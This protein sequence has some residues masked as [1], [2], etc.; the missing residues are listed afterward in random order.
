[1]DGSAT[2]TA[3]PRGRQRHVS[4]TWTAARR[5]APSPAA[6]AAQA[7][8]LRGHGGCRLALPFDN[9]ATELRDLLVHFGLWND[10]AA[11]I[12]LPHSQ[13]Q[14][15]QIRQARRLV[16]TKVMRLSLV[17]AVA[18]S[19]GRRGTAVSHIRPLIL[20]P[21]CRR[22]YLIKRHCADVGRQ[23]PARLHV[24]VARFGRRCAQAAH[25]DRINIVIIMA[26][27]Y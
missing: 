12:Q 11:A 6:C 9:V 4:D 27:L 10:T 21:L 26:T 20:N 13:A 3:A 5:A 18:S 7:E 19:V 1:M 25:H 15:G 24:D 17:P 23:R 8:Y 22:R 2:W 14:W 16:T